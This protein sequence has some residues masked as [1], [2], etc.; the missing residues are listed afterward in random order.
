[1]RGIYAFI[2]EQNNYFVELMQKIRG[3]I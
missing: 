3:K 1:M 2:I